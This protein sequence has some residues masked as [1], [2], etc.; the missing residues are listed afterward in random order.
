MLQLHTYRQS[1]RYVCEFVDVQCVYDEFLCVVDRRVFCALFCVKQFSRGP[2]LRK[3]CDM[4]P[5]RSSQPSV[6]DRKILH[7][8]NNLASSDNPRDVRDA[9]TEPGLLVRT[10]NISF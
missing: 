1:E 6:Q 4:T 7:R 9:E 10:T 8:R 2:V 3:F 5:P